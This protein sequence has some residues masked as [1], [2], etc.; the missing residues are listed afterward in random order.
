MKQSLARH[1]MEL[2]VIGSGAGKALHNYTFTD[3]DAAV[4]KH[5]VEYVSSLVEVAGEFDAMLMV[6]SMQGSVRKG[7]SR[8]QAMD[9]LSESL[10]RVAAKAAQMGVV[11]VLEPINRYETNLVNTLQQGRDLIRGVP[12]MA[13]VKL[14]ADLFHMNLE[15][16]DMG[17]SI[18]EA[19]GDI[20]HFHFV[21]SNRL[22]PGLGH[23][24][25]GSVA[26]AMRAAGY[27]GYL[28]VECFTGPDSDAALKRA[29]QTFDE[30]FG[31]PQQ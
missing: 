8:A 29:K 25:F 14:A 30:F 6:G 18:R 11:L 1:G 16:A 27:A 5:A 19:G 31:K 20:A 3:A 15:E 4:R 26:R 10:S 24:D 28:S 17:K 21:D 7:D 9:W 23:I 13:N 2:C 22:V 12:E